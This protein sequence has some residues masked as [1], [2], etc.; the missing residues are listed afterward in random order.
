MDSKAFSWAVRIIGVLVLAASNGALAQ[1]PK[2]VHFSGVINDYSPSNVKPTG[3]W[4]I[5]GPWNLTLKGES[6]KAD[7]SAALTM[8]L[9]DYSQNPSNVDSPGARGQ[10]TH[11]ITME[12]GIVMQIPGGGFEVSGPVDVTKDGSP[13]LAPSILKVDITGG[14]SVE[15]S[16]VTLTFMGPAMAHFGSQAIHGVVRSSKIQHEGPGEDGREP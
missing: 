13:V 14:M 2:P 3:P 6:G 15:F 7:F 16:N 12:G 1:A 11:H 5:R 8:E 9:S 4:E 10:H